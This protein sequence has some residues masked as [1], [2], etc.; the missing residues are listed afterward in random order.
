MNRTLFIHLHMSN[1]TCIQ[2][3]IWQH[4]NIV[5]ACKFLNKSS[6]LYNVCS[7]D[8]SLFCLPSL[9]KMFWPPRNTVKKQKPTNHIYNLSS[10]MPQHIRGQ[11]HLPRFLS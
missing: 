9:P 4:S 1:Q 7:A 5:N 6:I 2:Q 11:L 3:T 8:T 10:S